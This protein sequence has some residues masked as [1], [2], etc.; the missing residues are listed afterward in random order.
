MATTNKL[1]MVCP[2]SCMETFI[3]SQYGEDS[4]F[5]TSTAATF[6][7]GSNLYT[8]M[9]IDLIYREHITEIS[10]VSDTSCRFINNVL[11]RKEPFQTAVEREIDKLYVDSYP[12]LK[13]Y[14]NIMEKRVELASL[15][16]EKQLNELANYLLSSSVLAG[17]NIRL[18]G[19][20]TIVREN[21]IARVINYN[22]QLS[23]L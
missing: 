8:E 5:M 13:R 18:K 7:S 2:F 23:E 15:H 16:L 11:A 19:M 1:F 3:K 21:K 22:N 20:V 14:A 12:E 10:I 6:V 9:M 17:K 4:F